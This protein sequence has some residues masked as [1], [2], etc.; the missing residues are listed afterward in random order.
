VLGDD[1]ELLPRQP[2]YGPARQAQISDVQSGRAAALWTL[3]DPMLWVLHADSY[4][5]A[6]EVTGI[7]GEYDDAH[8]GR[9]MMWPASRAR[10]MLVSESGP[11][12]GSVSA[13]RRGKWSLGSDGGRLEGYGIARGAAEGD[14]THITLVDAMTCPDECIVVA[15]GA[16]ARY[17]LRE[18]TPHS[19]TISC[20]ATP[21]D[22]GGE[23]K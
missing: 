9:P 11:A 22:F 15:F 1:S 20:A 21:S 10:V 16:K 5:G 4:E 3:G 17:S 19:Q 8:G 18:A 7:V 23:Q 14:A 2:G 12:S 13:I 6:F